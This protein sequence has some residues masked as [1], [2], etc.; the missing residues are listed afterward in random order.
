MLAE[1]LEEVVVSKLVSDGRGSMEGD[2]GFFARL[3][4]SACCSNSRSCLDSDMGFWSDDSEL[5]SMDGGAR[6]CKNLRRYPGSC[7]ALLRRRLG[8]GLS[9]M[10]PGDVCG[11]GDEMGEAVGVLTLRRFVFLGGGRGTTRPIG[12]GAK[13]MR[14][15]LEK[16]FSESWRSSSRLH[17]RTT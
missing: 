6:E 15:P 5:P 7:G 14:R 3:R 2:S 1:R 13:R 10:E 4:I 12:P 16:S 9:D 11:R 8:S 17:S